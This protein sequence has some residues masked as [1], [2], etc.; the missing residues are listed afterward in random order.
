[1]TASPL[2]TVDLSAWHVHSAGVPAIL[3]AGDRAHSRAVGGESKAFVCVSGRTMVEYVLEALLHTRGVGDIYVI[4]DALRLQAQL[5]GSG[6]LEQAASCL[7]SSA[8]PLGREA[9]S[10]PAGAERAPAL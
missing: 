8:E 7:P 4:G 1:M 2:R 6:M 5:R 10:R 9:R 3:L